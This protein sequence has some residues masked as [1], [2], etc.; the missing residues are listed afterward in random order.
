MQGLLHACGV[1]LEASAPLPPTASGR[2]PHS[3]LHGGLR[4]G[5]PAPD[6]SGAAPCAAPRDPMSTS[7][8]AQSA[9]HQQEVEDDAGRYLARRVDPRVDVRPDPGYFSPAATVLPD[10]LPK[11]LAR[12]LV[13][14]RYMTCCSPSMVECCQAHGRRRSGGGEWPPATVTRSGSRR[15]VACRGALGPGVVVS[16]R[17][18]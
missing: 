9:S 6:T 1:T 16:C 5:R 10:V 7:G 3:G 18:D 17:C 13:R 11:V 4:S 12:T 2:G 14:G 8:A 15:G